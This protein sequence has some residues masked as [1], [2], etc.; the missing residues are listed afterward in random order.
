MFF[1]KIL[2]HENRI[3]LFKMHSVKLQNFVSVAKKN[4]AFAGLIC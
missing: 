2:I 1:S 3:I 4:P